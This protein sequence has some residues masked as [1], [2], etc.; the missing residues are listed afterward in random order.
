MTVEQCVFPDDEQ[1]A[2]PGAGTAVIT[3]S[4]VIPTYRR[5]DML[6]K[7]LA[8]CLAQQGVEDRFE[9]VVVDND[10]AGSAKPAVAAAASTGHA[11]IRYVAEARAGISHARNA[12]VAAAAGRYI[13]FIDDDEEAEPGWLAAFLS[14]I[15]RSAADAVI[16]PVYPRLPAGTAL[17]EDGYATSVYTRDARLPTGSVLPN[18]SGIGNALLDKERCFGAASEPF[19]PRLGLTGGEDSLFLRQLVRSSRKIVWCAEAVIWETIPIE[20]LGAQYLLRR[21]FRG[22]QTTTFVCT[23]MRPPQRGRAVFWMAVGCAQVA[24]YAPP[25]LLLRAINHRQWLPVA[26]KAVGGLGKVLW[27][28]KL[29]PRLYR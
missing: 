28:P 6:A 23:A 13:A 10:A 8:S 16:G 22:A 11:P 17:P 14:T 18:P 27:H 3:A 19:D 24:L 2:R 25:A 20:K 26:A 15:R 9:I 4:I 7:T 5:P 29:Q 12:G 21:T 1:G